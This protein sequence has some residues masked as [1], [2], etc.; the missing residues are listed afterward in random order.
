MKCPDLYRWVSDALKNVESSEQP[1]GQPLAIIIF[2][3]EVA[4]KCLLS[5]TVSLAEESSFQLT[6]LFPVYWHSRSD[7][8]VAEQSMELGREEEFWAT[9]EVTF[10]LNCLAILLDLWL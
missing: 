7:G 10:S 1:P 6:L 4:V 9:Q 2:Y 5:G 3:L 8:D